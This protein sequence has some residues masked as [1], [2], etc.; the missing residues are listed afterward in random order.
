MW[1]KSSIFNIFIFKDGYWDQKVIQVYEGNNLITSSVPYIWTS[2]KVNLGGYDAAAGGILV[3]ESQ[4][5][6]I[7]LIYYNNNWYP[8]VPR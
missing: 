2:G 8:V 4:V 3:K 5:G 1:R 6:N 7:A